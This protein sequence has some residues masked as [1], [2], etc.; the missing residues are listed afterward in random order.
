MGDGV[1]A[2][3]ASSRGGILKSAKVHNRTESMSVDFFAIEAGDTI[4]FIVDVAEQLN[5]DQFEWASVIQWKSQSSAQAA[6]QEIGTV[7]WDS[8]RDFTKTISL[9]LKPL[10][11]LAHSLLMSNEFIFVD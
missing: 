6:S 9:S 3:I 10:E 4:D 11:Q 1:A 7:T 2:W 5:T 8:R